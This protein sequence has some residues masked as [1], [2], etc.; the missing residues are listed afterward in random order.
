MGKEGMRIAFVR[1]DYTAKG[2]GAEKYLVTLSHELS[3]MGQEIHIFAHTFD[4]PPHSGI[5]IHPVSMIPVISPLKNLSFAF[6]AAKELKKF[7]FDIIFSLSRGF[8]HDI[9]RISDGLHP[10]HLAQRY[11]TVM[12]YLFKSL[13]PRH[14]TLLYLEKKSLT[15]PGLKRIVA[16]SHL[17][18]A[19]V[20]E[21]Y[22]IPS[23]K[24]EVIYNG[25]DPSIFNPSVRERYRTAM[26]KKFG[27]KGDDVVILFVAMDLERK[28][29]TYLLEAMAPLVKYPWTLLV[30]GK[31]DTGKYQ[32]MAEH[33]NLS[34]KVKFVG[35]CPQIQEIYGMGDMLVL[36][37][38]YDPFSNCCLEALACGI[39]VITTRQN[40]ASELIQDERNGYIVDDAG[41]VKDLSERIRLLLMN[42]SRKE[43]SEQVSPSV[44]GLTIEVNAK[45]TLKLFREVLDE[46]KIS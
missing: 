28:G 14:R 1:R 15:Q 44:E 9:F 36:P 18:K 42:E 23:E 45:K 27:V 5:Q 29:L 12:H 38:L 3:K 4:Q 20:M 40:G 7:T 31:P 41:N 30:T 2:G 17:A 34:D 16:N 39:P 13:T 6:N 8:Y 35:Y 37:T 10:Y 24:I 26:R 19:Q 22:G 25:I 32:K 46:K 11:R 33:L 43:M 21:Y